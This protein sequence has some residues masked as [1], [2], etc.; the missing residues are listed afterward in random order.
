M[1]L[2]ELNFA[3]SLLSVLTKLIYCQR[4]KDGSLSAPVGSTYLCL[5]LR[6][7]VVEEIKE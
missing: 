5:A 4:A 2:S 7:S 1:I 3:V 6:L